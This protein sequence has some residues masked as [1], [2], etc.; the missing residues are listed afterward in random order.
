LQLT[1]K[2]EAAGNLS[3]PPF[4][5]LATK[6]EMQRYSFRDSLIGI[7]CDAASFWFCNI[8]MEG[9]NF[10]ESRPSRLAD[11]AD[12]LLFRARF[13]LFTQAIHYREPAVSASWART[14]GLALRHRHGRGWS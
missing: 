2:L 14:P 4:F 10:V 11:S 3:L 5:C 13:G 8:R 7:V 9:A 1:D 12:L 6:P